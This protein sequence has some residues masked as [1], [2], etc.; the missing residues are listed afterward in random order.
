[1]YNGSKTFWEAGGQTCSVRVGW[2]GQ[3]ICFVSF[4][5]PKTSSVRNFS[6]MVLSGAN[7]K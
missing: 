4:V 6:L 3:A 1:M 5:S 2:K 7:N